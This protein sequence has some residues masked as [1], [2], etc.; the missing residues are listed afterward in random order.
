M[1]FYIEP[2]RHPQEH[3]HFNL[4]FC[5]LSEKERHYLGMVGAA[6]DCTASQENVG[7]QVLHFDTREELE[8]FAFFLA[9]AKEVAEHFPAHSIKRS[10]DKQDDSSSGSAIGLY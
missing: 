3:C 1:E 5:D 4:R 2:V 7:T 9:I 10:L 6:F 8:K